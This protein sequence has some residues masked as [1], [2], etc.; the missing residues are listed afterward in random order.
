V[1]GRLVEGEAKKGQSAPRLL[2]D[3]NKTELKAVRKWFKKHIAKDSRDTYY[4][5]DESA[6]APF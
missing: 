3:L 2:E 5:I 1:V 6:E 4:Y